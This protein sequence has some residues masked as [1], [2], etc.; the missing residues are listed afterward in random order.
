MTKLKF[1]AVLA[2]AL[3]AGCS[4]TQ[5]LRESDQLS[6]ARAAEASSYLEQMR[7]GQVTSNVRVVSEGHYMPL[8]EVTSDRPTEQP[9]NC[10]IEYNP[11]MAATL[12]EIGQAVSESCGVVVRVTPDAA[13]AVRRM[14]SSG[15]TSSGSNG[16]DT[17]QETFDENGAP[18][19]PPMSLMENLPMVGSS[20]D[21]GDLVSIAWSGPVEGL[22]DAVTSRL[23]LSWRHRDG[24]VSIFHLDTRIYRVQA[25]PSTSRMESTVHSG[26]RSSAGVSTGTSGGSRE[27]SGGIS[28]SSGSNQLTSVEVET[29]FMDD[30]QETVSQMLTPDTGRMALSRASGTLS[31]TDTPETLDRIGLYVDQLNEFTTK[32]VLL[33]VKVLNVT[34]NSSDEMGINWN[35]IYTNLADQYG[36]RLSNAINA[37]SEAVS[38]SV[39]ILEGSSRFSGSELIVN[40]LAQIGKVSVVTQPSVTTLNLEPVPVQ[41]ARQVSYLERVEL[42]Q[43]AQVGST[44]SLTPGSVTTGFNMMLLPHIL[45]DSRTVLLQYSMNLSTLD[46]LR[47]VSS[48][49]STIEIPEIDNRIFNQKVRLRSNE[50]LII[51]GFEQLANDSRRSGVGSARFWPFGGGARGSSRRDVIVVLITPVVIA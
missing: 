5:N 24:V 9:V 3:L 30:L 37:S 23:G 7:Q 10:A 4:S 2:A 11:V 17:H 19:L 36:L 8:R 12:Q 43:T 15:R 26:A 16:S 48:G 44:T 45:D 33:N 34:L 46:N 22:L 38:G 50:T 51:S 39:S 31:V 6:E 25:I 27:S 13:A 32:Q 49:G 18:N 29:D 42:G 40:A 47:T 20:R 35:A 1:A 14:A 28:G 21:R 41:V